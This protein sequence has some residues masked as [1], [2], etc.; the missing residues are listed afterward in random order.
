LIQFENQPTALAAALV[1][2]IEDQLA[3]TLDPKTLELAEIGFAGVRMQVPVGLNHYGT[4]VSVS[5]WTWNATNGWHRGETPL[6]VDVRAGV[7]PETGLLSLTLAC[8]D[9]NTGTFP[10]DPYAGF[11]PPNRPETFYYPTNGAACC[12]GVVDTN[13]LIQPGQGYLTYTVRPKTNLATGTVI[14]NAARIVFDWNDPIDTPTVF[15]TIDAGA[16]ASAVAALPPEVG[17]TFLVRWSGQ[18]DPGGSG[19]SSYDVYLSTDGTNYTRWLENTTATAAYLQGDLGQ[20]YFFKVHARDLVGNEETMHV[21][22]DAQTTVSSNSPVLGAGMSVTASVNGQLLVTNQ[23]QGGM[24]GA[25]QYW[26]GPGAPEGAEINP[27]NGILRWTP[28]CGQASRTFPITVWVA[29]TANTNLMDTTTLTVTVGECIV[30]G[31]GRV[32]LQAGESNR[33]PVNLISSVPLTNLSMTVDAPMDRLTGLWLEPIVPEIC[34]AQIVPLSNSV[35]RLSLATCSNQFLIG[36]QQ[37]AWL[38]FTTLSNQS[39]AFVKLALDNTVGYQ[40]DGTEVRNFGPQS[41]QLV[42]IGEEPLLEAVA[43][44]PQQAN[45]ILYG[46]PG[47][48]YRILSCPS[49]NGCD[50]WQPFWQGSQVDLFQTLPITV[51]PNQAQFFRA[52]RQ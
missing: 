43:T 6:M 47:P 19:L 22:A 38:H 23:V 48:N 52:R 42:V 36:T 24:S 10:A 41:G 26:L 32:V 15:N 31:L 49:V 46:K 40:S 12:G 51:T 11:L 50:P 25:F 30:P 39:S 29:D 14:T 17:R 20:R 5:G 45:L 21:V 3:P 37:V 16:P 2:L 13:Q 7:D 9:T 35:Y 33:V 27:A 28:K 4:R 8:V 1:V 44:G 34:G 18:D